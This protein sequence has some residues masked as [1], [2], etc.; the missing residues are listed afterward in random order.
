MCVT[1][2]KSKSDESFYI[3][4]AFINEKGKSTSRIYRKLGKLSVLSRELITDR[5]G[6]MTWAKEQ[7]R[8]ETKNIIKKMN[9][10]LFL[11]ILIFQSRRI[12]RPNC[13]PDEKDESYTI[14]KIW[15]YPI[16]YK[17]R[18]YR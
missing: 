17:N 8:I 6:V 11:F 15:I 14:R 16:L 9:L 7:A 5:D 18:Y 3:N 12:S 10:F 1:T 13:E 4:Y 2:I